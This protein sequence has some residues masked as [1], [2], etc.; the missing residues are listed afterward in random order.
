MLCAGALAV[1]WPGSPWSITHAASPTTSNPTAASALEAGSAAKASRADEW[2]LSFGLDSIGF[3]KGEFPKGIE[4]WLYPASII[5]VLLALAAAR[6]LDFLAHSFL[7]RWSDRSKTKFDDVAMTLLDGPIKVIAFV[8]LLNLGL[9]GLPWPPWIENYLTNAL[10]IGVALSVTY[11][12]TK[13]GDLFIAY[14]RARTAAD[15]DKSFDEHLLPIL[16]KTLKVF[17]VVVAVL[18][19]AQ[20][21]GVNITSLIASLSIG[22]LAVGLAAQDTLANVFGAVSVLVDKPFRVGDRIKLDTIDGTVEAIGLRS[23]RIRNLDGFL[24]TV[25]NKT[26]GGATITNVSQRPTI[27]TE[28]N[29]GVT[30][31]TPT[32]KLK[33]A[34]EIITEIYKA[35]P[36]TAD[37][38]VGFNKFADSALNINVI[39]WWNST[40]YK[41][42]LEGMQTMNLALKKRFD[43]EGIEF[44][45]PS[46]TVYV[47]TGGAPRGEPPLNP[48]RSV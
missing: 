8:I 10:T 40:D 33:R 26:I 16:R 18:V 34:V 12:A 25:P 14:W 13:F 20:N 43:E 19:T 7:K 35:H 5:Y 6:L 41:A 24:V 30:Y 28:M 31:D 47:K 46:Q 27:K 39:H 21:M 2:P 32:E 22:G 48:A 4:L 1:L 23:T 11:M 29:I 3:L 37:L 44:A 45:F 36:M 38:S 17:I 9:E 15:T 42:H